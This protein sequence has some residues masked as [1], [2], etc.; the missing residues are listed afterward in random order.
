MWL[1]F[2]NIGRYLNR[3]VYHCKCQCLKYESITT[4][5]GSDKWKVGSD[6]WG[7]MMVVTYNMNGIRRSAD[8]TNIE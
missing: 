1:S 6:N 7:V 8:Q 3:G 2:T 5:M 4:Q